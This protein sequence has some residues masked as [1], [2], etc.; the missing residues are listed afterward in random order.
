MRSWGG[1]EGRVVERERRRGERTAFAGWV[2][3]ALG[4]E[5]R[6]A[7]SRDLSARGLG[8]ALDPPHPGVGAPVESEFALPGFHLP[9]AVPAR[10]AWSDPAGGRLGLAF[11]G[12]DLAVLELLESAVAGR[13]QRG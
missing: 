4:V 5:R 7:R 10:V 12:L 8:L 11:D 1:S 2:E 6:L 3:L 9:L 13:F